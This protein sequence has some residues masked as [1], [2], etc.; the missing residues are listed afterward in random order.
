MLKWLICCGAG[1]CALAAV[2][3]LVRPHPVAAGA[4]HDVAH[5]GAGRAELWRRAE[6]W[7]LR[8]RGLKTGESPGLALVLVRAADA[9]D[10]EDVERA[11]MVVLGPVPEKQGDFAVR[12]P[13]GLDPTGY[14]AVAVWNSRYRVNF[15]TAPLR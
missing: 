14:R 7:E 9:R 6:G 13:E 8:V 10:N 5:H 4:F 11:G 1:V 15:T 3:A 12:L 2:A